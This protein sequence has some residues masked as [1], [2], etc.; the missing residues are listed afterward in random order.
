MTNFQAGSAFVTSLN[1]PGMIFDVR[2]TESAPPLGRTPKKS[3]MLQSCQCE[4]W[5]FTCWTET[6]R[7]HI[8]SRY[9]LS[10]F[11]CRW[12]GSSS[13]RFSKL[14]FCHEIAH[15]FHFKRLGVIGQ[16]KP[17]TDCRRRS[18][19]DPAEIVPFS[20]STVQSSDNG[21]NIF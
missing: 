9:F 14:L 11:R 6:S 12:R 17:I 20:I 21:Y 15:S 5:I 19:T 1:A 4:N 18:S 3:S 2:A 7:L 10:S 16:F 8:T 13:G